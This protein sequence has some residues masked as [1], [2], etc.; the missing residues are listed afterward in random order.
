MGLND[1]FEGKQKAFS[2]AMELP[3][4]F[5]KETDCTSP[6]QVI[7]TNFKNVNG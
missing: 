1:A 5:V 2:A 7:T 3:N 6:K 4:K